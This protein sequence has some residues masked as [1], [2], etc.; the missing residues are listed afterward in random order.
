M[1][2]TVVTLLRWSLTAASWLVRALVHW[3]GWV[4]RGVG[5]CL[6]AVILITRDTL[7]C[8]GCGAPISLVGRWECGVCQYIFDGFAFTRCDVCGAIPPY[9]TCQGCG[10]SVKNPTL[11][12]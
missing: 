2:R 11:F 6:G 4:Y 1:M 10:M 9:V 7:R 8:H 12:P 5:R 3:A